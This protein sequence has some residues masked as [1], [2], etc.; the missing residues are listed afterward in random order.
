MVYIFFYKNLID[1]ELIR[2]INDKFDIFD[3]YVLVK[4]YDEEN[5]ILKIS[6]IHSDNNVILNGKIVKL[7]MALTF[8]IPNKILRILSV[9][10]DIL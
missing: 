9:L 10:L 2:K 6:G 3:G 7:D 8:I 4:S 5:D 1:P